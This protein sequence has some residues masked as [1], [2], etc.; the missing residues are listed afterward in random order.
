MSSVLGATLRAL[1]VRAH[2]QGLELVCQQ[3]PGVP[4]ALIGDAVRLRQVL[5]NLVGNA[6]K[7]TERGEV[8]L[9][10]EAEPALDPLDRQEATVRFIVRDTGIGIPVDKQATIF[11][12]FEQ[13][14]ASTTRKYGGT[15]LGLTIAAQLVALMGGQ[16]SVNSSPGDGSTFT[17]TARF[18]L[19]PHSAEPATVQT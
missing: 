10:V 15:G 12:P 13:E 6:I 3:R 18:G 5:L 8:V 16:I 11:R 4:D 7:F 2:K 9:Q 1:S 19:Q 17:F 14:D